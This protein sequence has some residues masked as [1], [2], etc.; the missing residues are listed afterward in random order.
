MV[1]FVR[2]GDRDGECDVAFAGGCRCRDGMAAPDCARALTT[3]R[4][5]GW[6]VGPPM[7]VPGGSDGRGCPLGCSGKGICLGDRCHCASGYDGAACERAHSSDCISGCNGR[8]SCERGFCTCAPGWAGFDC[9]LPALACAGNCNS[10]GRCVGGACECDDGWTGAACEAPLVPRPRCPLNCSA[11]GACSTGGSCI[12]Q[13]GY[14]GPACERLRAERCPLGCCGHG[15]CRR[16][17]SAIESRAVDTRVCVCD[18]YWDG[19]D[20]CSPVLRNVCPDH[21]HA[22]GECIRGQ[23]A[24]SA[25]WGGPSCAH[26]APAPGCARNC[27]GHGECRRGKCECEPGFRG[28]MCEEGDAYD[29]PPFNVPFNHRVRRW[30]AKATVRLH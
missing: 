23:C 16:A 29:A 28:A 26:V 21:C 22:R 8:G 3:H 20:C 14:A 24:C 30:A 10:H 19:D 5:G 13:P 18:L 7:A 6:L 11:H 25:G 15:R 4:A 1:Q 27:S 9:S 17:P 12:C 2:T